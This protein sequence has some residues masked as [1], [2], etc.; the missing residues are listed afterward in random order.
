MRRRRQALEVFAATG[1]IEAAS[2]AIWEG[3][4]SSAESAYGAIRTLLVREGWYAPTGAR[5]P[6]AHPELRAAAP[7]VRAALA[8]GT[9]DRVP[10]EVPSPS[11]RRVFDEA[12]LRDAAFMYFVDGSS[13]REVARRLLPRANTT[14][15]QT[16]FSALLDEWNRRGWPRRTQSAAMKWRRPKAA[17]RC[18]ARTLA[19]KRCARYAQTGK[20]WCFDHDPERAEEARER[21]RRASQMAYIDAVPVDPF[22]Y[23][24]RH[25]MRELGSLKAV[26]RRVEGTISYDTLSR[27][28]HPWGEV[29]STRAKVARRSTID[30]ILLAWGDGTT[31]EDVYFPIVDD[32]A[33]LVPKEQAA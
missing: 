31:F 20:A 18:R 14:N 26:H 25:R 29:G 8:N 1:S 6:W 23:W 10:D 21:N 4:F 24:L 7:R 17:K 30:R 2:K 16:L 13:F 5:G 11:Q 12:L 32:D 28:A 9:W 27:W 22:A 19:G 15:V 33:A 3:L